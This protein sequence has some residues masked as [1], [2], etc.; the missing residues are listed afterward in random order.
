MMATMT[1]NKSAERVRKEMEAAARQHNI[2]LGLIDSSRL[3][4]YRSLTPTNLEEA[5]KIIS[6]LRAELDWFE[7]ARRCD[8]A[9]MRAVE[10]HDIMMLDK[11]QKLEFR[12]TALEKELK[13]KKG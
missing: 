11:V 7:A 10:F 9:A 2:E 5:K 8:M 12:M 4:L 1:K 6:V 3:V 13:V